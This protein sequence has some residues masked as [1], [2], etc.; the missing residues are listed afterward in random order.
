PERLTEDLVRAVLRLRH[1]RVKEGLD[2]LR[3][4]QEDLQVQG[5]INLESYN[6]MILNYSRTR[7]RLDQAL[8]QPI[9]LD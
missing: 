3:N 4:F 9:Q 2:Q 8:S 7:D 1:V 5:D 6:E